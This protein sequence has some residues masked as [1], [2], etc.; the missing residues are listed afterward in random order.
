MDTANNTG[1]KVKRATRAKNHHPADDLSFTRIRPKSEWEGT[2]LFPR[3]WWSVSPSGDYSADC[4]T[5][6]H[7]AMEYLE[8]SARADGSSC[9]ALVVADMPAE[10]SG[11]EIAFLQLVGFAATAGRERAGAIL[12]YW[13]NAEKA[14]AA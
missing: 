3:C 2:T 11:I 9:L 14:G 5:G 8:Y 6:Q 4:N 12:K 1:T 13:D 10:Q 7:M